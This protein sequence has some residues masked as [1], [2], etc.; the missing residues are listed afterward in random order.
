MTCYY[1]RKAWAPLSTADGGRYVFD[2]TKAL[3]SDNP[4]ALPCGQC[5]GCRADRASS[6]ATRCTHEAQVA[7]A[8]CFITLTYDDDHLPADN[9]VSLREWQLFMKRL[10]KR[11]GSRIRYFACGE[12]GE[13]N[14]RAHYHALLFNFD[15]PDKTYWATRDG[16]RVFKSKALE[17]LWPYGLCEVGSVT[18]QSAGY[19][20]QYAHKKITGLMAVDHYLRPHPLTGEL[21]RVAPEFGAMSRRPGLGEEW[22]DR[23]HGD[24][25][26]ADHLIVDG[27]PRKV[28]EYYVKRL[29]LMKGETEIERLKR[30]R[31]RRGFRYSFEHSGEHFRSSERADADRTPARL[32]VRDFIHAERLKRLVRSL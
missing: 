2:A 30:K 20:A 7:P 19:C 18:A 8:S 11:F 21:H 23:Y 9:S 27:S 12:Y 3:N 16:N 25:F 17:E 31:R 10:R 6:W 1:P 15:F 22:F 13:E 14:G 29:A 32:V 4:V 5:R 28:P 24:V 26:P